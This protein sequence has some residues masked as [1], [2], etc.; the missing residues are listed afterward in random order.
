MVVVIIALIA[1]PR[2]TTHVLNIAPDK[3]PDLETSG[4]SLYSDAHYGMQ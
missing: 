4:A 3:I 1:V 2:W